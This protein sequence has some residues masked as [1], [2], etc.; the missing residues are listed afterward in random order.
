[1]TTPEQATA[2][3]IANFSDCHVGILTKLD[4]LGELPGLLDAATRARNTAQEALEFFR[5]AVFEHHAEEERELFPA[6]FSAAQPGPERDKVKALG[7][8]LTREHRGIETL[9]KRL[10]PGLKRVAKGQDSD[11][12]AGE[13]SLLVSQYTAHARFEEA[14]YLPLAH[15][16]LSRSSQRMAALGLALHLRHAPQVVGYV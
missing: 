8:R 6:V 5:E 13:L 3:P 14:E 1:M 15:D 12:D 10:E 11:L 4:R 16:I 2:A 7:E 9:W